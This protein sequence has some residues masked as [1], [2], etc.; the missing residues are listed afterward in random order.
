MN[1]AA[2]WPRLRWV[3]AS[4]AIIT[5]ITALVWLSVGLG[6]IGA[7][8]LAFGLFRPDGVDLHRLTGP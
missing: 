6:V 1:L 4:A 2:A 8:L 7:A 3:L 5:E